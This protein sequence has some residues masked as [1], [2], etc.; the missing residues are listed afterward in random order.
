MY[1]YWL[2]ELE[3]QNNLLINLN[4]LEKKMEKSLSRFLRMVCFKKES[5]TH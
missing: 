2:A 3:N 1:E 4:S 5:K